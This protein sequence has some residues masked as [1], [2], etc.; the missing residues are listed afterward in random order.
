[1]ML[2]TGGAGGF[3]RVATVWR[4]GS[5]SSTLKSLILHNILCPSRKEFPLISPSTLP[6][7]PAF[8]NDDVRALDAKEA[9]VREQR[10]QR[11]YGHDACRVCVGR[12]LG[13]LVLSLSLSLFVS[14]SLSL[15]PDTLRR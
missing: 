15:V 8:V 2:G 5:E 13:L 4:L 3:R 9:T 11:K 6:R 12:C 14:L 10:V 7:P 1:M